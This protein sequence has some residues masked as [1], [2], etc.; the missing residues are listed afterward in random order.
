[1]PSEK[2]S[3]ALHEILRNIKLAEQFTQGHTFATLQVDEKTLYAVVR[4]LEIISEASRRL[5]DELKARHAN[6]EWR[7]MA[8][9]GNV[10][11]HSYEDVTAR[12]VWKTLHDHLPALRAVV[13]K[14]LRSSS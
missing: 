5:T 7:E 11:R 14:E 9:A 8:A 6:I 2:E 4:S 1:M 13:E 10:Y 12:R 3:G